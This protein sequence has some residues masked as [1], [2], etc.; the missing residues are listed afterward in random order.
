MG[1]SCLITD[2]K[3]I[4]KFKVIFDITEEAKIH[5][6]YA[7]AIYKIIDSNRNGQR[8]R[9]LDHLFKAHQTVL[10]NNLIRLYDEHKNSTGLKRFLN[11]LKYALEKNQSKNLDLITQV[12]EELRELEKDKDLHNKLKIYRDKKAFH[13]DSSNA[14]GK[15]PLDSLGNPIV[16][17]SD[18]IQNLLNKAIKII[19][20]YGGLL[21][22][23][24]NQFA[25]IPEEDFFEFIQMIKKWCL[26]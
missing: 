26:N 22:L 10:A 14:S 18:E 17:S 1:S 15:I 11:D 24:S 3:I 19:S 7:S 9:F 6:T 12:K 21:Y 20:N 13:L 5:E 4:K 25:C 8:I 23:K 16:I 2:Q